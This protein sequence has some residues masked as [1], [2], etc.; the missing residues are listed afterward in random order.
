[1]TKIVTMIV[2]VLLS[3][4][5]LI[6]SEEI[7]MRSVATNLSSSV[8]L[9]CNSQAPWFFCVWE[10]PRGDRI[11]SLRSN[12]GRQGDRDRCGESHRMNIQGRIATYI[13]FTKL[14][15]E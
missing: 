8:V 2:V 12:I 11:C 15:R 6:K 9:S 1:M 7:V 13:D 4:Q 10:G 5:M 3:D 14:R